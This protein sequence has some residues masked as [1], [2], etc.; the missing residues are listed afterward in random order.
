MAED[1]R[2]A[3]AVQSAFLAEVGLPVG[4]VAQEMAPT[5]WAVEMQGSACDAVALAG[6][7]HVA[8]VANPGKLDLP[9]LGPTDEGRQSVRDEGS[10]LRLT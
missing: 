4:T 7:R 1:E 8:D 9:K 2:S 5:F 10:G 3:S 6:L